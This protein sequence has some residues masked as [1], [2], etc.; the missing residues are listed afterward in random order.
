MTVMRSVSL[1]RAWA[2][3]VKRCL[4]FGKAAHN[5]KSGQG[6]GRGIDVKRAAFE[7]AAL[8]TKA[9]RR[10]NDIGTHPAQVV[11][12]GLV[13]LCVIHVKAF[14]NHIGIG[15]CCRAQGK[16][17][18]RPVSGNGFF[19]RAVALASGN[20]KAGVAFARVANLLLIQPRKGQV[21]IGQLRRV[22]NDDLGVIC[23]ASGQAMSRLDTY[24]DDLEASSTTVPPFMRPLM[25]SGGQ[26][27]QCREI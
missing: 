18:R 8:H 1:T 9:L 24:W 4:S 17:G 27:F 22:L 26:P 15:E 6:I 14:K 21:D 16:G 13:A 20:D 12:N 23:G 11:D 19:K 3:F 10:L 2:T 5:R 25:E 7:C